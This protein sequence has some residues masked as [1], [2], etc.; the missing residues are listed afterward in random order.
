MHGPGELTTYQAKDVVFHYAGDF[1]KGMMHGFGHSES[2]TCDYIGQYCDGYEHGWGIKYFHEPISCLFIG[3]LIDGV[4]GPGLIEYADG[5]RVIAPFGYDQD[6]Q[7]LRQSSFD[8]NFG[9][10]QYDDE[11]LD[12]SDRPPIARFIGEIYTVGVTGDDLSFAGLPHGHGEV[13]WDNGDKS[14][15]LCEQGMIVRM[16]DQSNGKEVD[17]PDDAYVFGRHIHMFRKPSD[18][19]ERDN[20]K[21]KRKRKSR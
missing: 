14:F 12:Q 20:N 11:S 9:Y 7:P 5:T 8:F 13:E 6:M 18:E 3:Q 21:R 19:V 17:V 4:I 10:D 1:L 2:L 15:V 16:I